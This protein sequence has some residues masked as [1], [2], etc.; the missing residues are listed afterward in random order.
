MKNGAALNIIEL[1]CLIN[2]L[3]N[4]GECTGLSMEQSLITEPFHNTNLS[5]SQIV[6]LK[7]SNSLFWN[8]F[9]EYNHNVQKQI[10]S[11]CP[12]P[13]NS[14]SARVT[15]MENLKNALIFFNLKQ[16]FYNLAR[17]VL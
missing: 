14:V 16:I 11:D 6:V 8:K 10:C 1:E 5:T 15:A 3:T 13:V 17:W 2:R 7:W 4:T 9:V 12:Y